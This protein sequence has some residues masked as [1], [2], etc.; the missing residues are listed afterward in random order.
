MDKSIEFAVG[1]ITLLIIGVVVSIVMPLAY[2]IGGYFTGWIL[3]SVFTFA[4]Q[5]VVSG[6]G[7]LG[8]EIP[9][10]SLPFIGAFLAFAGSFFSSHQTN[11]N[12]AK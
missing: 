10:T 3:S 6:A 5:W 1:C 11:T 9:I 2:A 8:V 4:G 12:K 7:S